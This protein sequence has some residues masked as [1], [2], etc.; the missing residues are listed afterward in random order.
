[1]N[2]PYAPIEPGTKGTVDLVDDIETVSAGRTNL[3]ELETCCGSFIRTL[4]FHMNL[5][6][7]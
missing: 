4:E 6:K 2:D 7:F 1:M 3:G 5:T